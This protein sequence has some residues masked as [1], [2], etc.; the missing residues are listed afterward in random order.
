MIKSGFQINLI[1]LIHVISRCC[2]SSTEW[3]YFFDDFDVGRGKLGRLF[4][5]VETLFRSRK[6]DEESLYIIHPF[7]PVLICEHHYM[8]T[9]RGD[10]GSGGNFSHFLVNELN[11]TRL[12]PYDVVCCQS[13]AVKSFV[14]NILP[15]LLDPII[16]ITHRWNLPELVQSTYTDALLNDSR[17]AHWFAHN[18]FFHTSP[19]FSAFPYG[20][21]TVHLKAYFRAIKLYKESSLTII[22]ASNKTSY[23]Y[24]FKRSKE[25]VANVHFTVQNHV[26][27][28][29]LPFNNTVLKG[30]DYYKELAN[31]KYVI[32]PHG[33]RPD[34][35]RHWELI[36]LGVVPIAN[37]DSSLFNTFSSRD[38]H[39]IKGLFSGHLPSKSNSYSTRT[40]SLLKTIIVNGTKIRGGGNMIFMEVD[41]IAFL[42]NSPKHDDGTL[43]KKFERAWIPP[44]RY[45]TSAIY[46]ACKVYMMKENFQ[47]ERKFPNGTNIPS[48]SSS[49]SSA[50][51]DNEENLDDDNVIYL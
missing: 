1:A 9:D 31:Y 11:V 45:L 46:W 30:R 13:D 24:P 12:G 40:D 44:Q 39:R 6:A 20:I 28:Q 17:I 50:D 2:G 16:L 29:R 36:G 18:P 43:F 3:N 48:S 26:S 7:S 33:D 10:Y 21:C 47:M 35:Y 15:Q 19:K 34:C 25:V 49:L 23:E 51:D 22:T 27:R 14:Q 32:S 38:R 5:K 37:I 42:L 41:D 8:W 4:Q